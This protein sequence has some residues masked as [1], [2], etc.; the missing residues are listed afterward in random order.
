MAGI[1]GDRTSGSRNSESVLYVRAAIFVAFQCFLDPS[2]WLL[3]S[4]ETANDG[5]YQLIYMKSGQPTLCV[6]VYL[7]DVF[8]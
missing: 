5:K 8:N 3:G 7:G 4:M 1:S 6:R 2:E